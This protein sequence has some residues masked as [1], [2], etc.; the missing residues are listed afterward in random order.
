MGFSVMLSG[1]E[2]LVRAENWCHYGTTK[3]MYVQ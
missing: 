1:A 2:K 3:Y